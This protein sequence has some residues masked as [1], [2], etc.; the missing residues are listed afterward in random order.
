MQRSKIYKLK[1]SQL[2]S[3]LCA[4]YRPGLGRSGF[5]IRA[6]KLMLVL[7]GLVIAGCAGTPLQK[8]EI[9]NVYACSEY[10]PG[11]DNIYRKNVYRGVS[12]ERECQKLDGRLYSYGTNWVCLVQ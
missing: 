1:L 3:I 11:P 10:C 2:Y 12:D 5:F 8:P 7:L 6:G 4:R 9:I